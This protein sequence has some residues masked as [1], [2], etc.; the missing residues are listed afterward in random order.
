MAYHNVAAYL[1]F[2]IAGIA[3]GAHAY[4]I[5]AEATQLGVLACAALCGCAVIGCICGF[6]WKRTLRLHGYYGVRRQAAEQGSEQLP[7]TTVIGRVGA[8]GAVS[9]G[10][11]LAALSLVWAEKTI[12]ACLGFFLSGTFVSIGLIGTGLNIAVRLRWR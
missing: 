3:V 8:A 5:G 4:Y 9:G 6:N 12:I 11:L 2:L 1:A 7:N 10:A